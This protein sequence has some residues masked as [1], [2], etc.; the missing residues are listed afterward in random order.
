MNREEIIGDCQLILGDCREVLP[1]LGKVDCIV[2]DLPYKLESGGNTTGEMGGK[3]KFSA[4]DI[5][6]IIEVSLRLES[7]R[8]PDGRMGWRWP[9]TEGS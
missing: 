3:F 1:T 9:G 8:M 2:S 5:A 4:G 7:A 6:S